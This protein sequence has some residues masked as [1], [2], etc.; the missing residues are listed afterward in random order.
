MS[1]GLGDITARAQGLV[2]TGD[3]GGAKKLLDEALAG[4][5]PQSAHASPELAEAAALQARVLVA[6]GDPQAAR[7]W[8]AF[9]HSATTR[10]YGRQD[11]RSVSAAATLAA[12]LHRVGSH[13]RAAR[14]YRDVIAELSAIDGPESL[15]TLAAHADLA[16]VE[17][18]RG[19]CET[20]R[21]RL[22]DAWELHR[23]VYGDGHPAGMKM[24]A[25]LGAMQRDCGRGTE[26][27]DHLALARELCREH[28]SA[29]HPLALQVAALA[30]A[31]ADPDHVCEV[32]PS[33][34]HG[35]PPTAGPRAIEPQ[36]PV[37]EAPAPPPPIRLPGF[38]P[39]EQGVSE[40]PRFSVAEQP[41]W[42]PAI[43]PRTASDEEP[44]PTSGAGAATGDDSD[45]PWWPPELAGPDDDT[46]PIP[47]PP[48][49]GPPLDPEFLSAARASAGA[50][51][52]GG[53]AF[54]PRPAAQPSMPVYDPPRRRTQPIVVA[55]LVFI[56]FIAVTV[57]VSL[58][59]GGDPAPRA[60]T[61]TAPGTSAATGSPSD[62][63]PSTPATPVTSTTVAAPPA[64]AGAPPTGVTL[65]DNRD[66]V[67][68]TWTYPAGA[69]GP[70]LISGGRSGQQPRA[71]Q[72]IPAGTTTYVVYGL[73]E[74]TD[75]C[76]TV[77][78]I[79]ST[80]TIGRAAPVCT[81]R[82]GGSNR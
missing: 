16:T 65:R 19:Q 21:N 51:H 81:A 38:S 46:P 39:A 72:E 70:V 49:A 24:L 59:L 14:L 32:M 64:P 56:L 40:T 20:A 26:A 15:R 58:A 31:A 60:T 69:E 25:R 30:D 3:L 8:A 62:T 7:G 5:D 11:E 73:N 4:G 29:E 28:L 12:V 79:Y 45:E 61:A 50:P 33:P 9:A 53:I 75:Y 36:P 80:D 63:P 6:L 76:F 27:H 67:T 57:I 47:D 66:S 71:F 34:S 18:A 35:D 2:G 54:G 74:R 48:T 22:E 78:V 82:T 77:A 17:Y 44:G 52:P 55:T 37:P 10:L 41:L 43:P 23:E 13:A 42:P 1:F 68:L